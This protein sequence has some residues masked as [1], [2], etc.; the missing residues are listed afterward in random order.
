MP[1]VTY[2]VVQP[3]LKGRGGHRIIPGDAVQVPTKRA[4]ERAVEALRGDIVGAIAFSR[5]GDPE[6]G[7]W[8]DAIVLAQNGELPEEAIAA[9]VPW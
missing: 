6:D 3:F 1:E 2:Y 7:E 8:A 4:A 5:T 9:S